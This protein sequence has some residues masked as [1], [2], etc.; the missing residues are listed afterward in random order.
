MDPVCGQPSGLGQAHCRFTASDKPSK[1]QAVPVRT[2]RRLP[3]PA[4]EQ[5]GNHSSNA[6][7]FIFFLFKKY[8]NLKSSVLLKIALL[9]IVTFI[10]L[11]LAP[12]KSLGT[13][14]RQCRQV[15]SNY[16]ALGVI[17]LALYFCS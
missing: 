17:A 5:T 9:V 1:R 16:D 4:G 13:V 12:A 11:G 3:G 14:H 8:F 15:N 6:S 7:R 10:A 2:H